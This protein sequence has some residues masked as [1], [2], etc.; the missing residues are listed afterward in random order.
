MTPAQI[1]AFVVMYATSIM[2]LTSATWSATLELGCA[3]SPKALA[4]IRQQ[5]LS[6]ESLAPNINRFEPLGAALLPL[7]AMQ[8]RM[9]MASPPV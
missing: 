5:Y 8:D 2:N 4:M 7:L 3:F 1:K 6:I 9:P